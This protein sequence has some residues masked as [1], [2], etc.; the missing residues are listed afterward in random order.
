[1]VCYLHWDI[2]VLFHFLFIFIFIFLFFKSLLRHN[3]IVHLRSLTEIF[4]RKIGSY[5]RTDIRTYNG[6]SIFC[7]LRVFSIL[8]WVESV[9]F[10]T[11]HSWDCLRYLDSVSAK[12]SEAS[13]KRV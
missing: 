1:M 12:Y 2:S 9:T 8:S 10:T 5:G 11:G 13:I 4:T 6:L 7:Q 3:D